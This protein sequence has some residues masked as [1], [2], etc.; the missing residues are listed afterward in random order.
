MICWSCLFHVCE[1]SCLITFGLFVLIACL[2]F[3]KILVSFCIAMVSLKKLSS[4]RCT[5]TMRKG[6]AQRGIRKGHTQRRTFPLRRSRTVAQVFQ[7]IRNDAD[8]KLGN[9]IHA[10]TQS[11]ALSA[12]S[13]ASNPG[14]PQS[15]SKVL[16][17]VSFRRQ[18]SRTRP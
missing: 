4:R 7:C 17:A 1:S 6:Y 15:S 18:S 9:F 14:S 16:H 10:V 8:T 2:L 3:D 11:V 5:R 12:L 13:P